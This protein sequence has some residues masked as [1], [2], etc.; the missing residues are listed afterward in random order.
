MSVAAAPYCAETAPPAL[1]SYS[2]VIVIVFVF[3]G[4]VFLVTVVEV[5]RRFPVSRLAATFI[6]AR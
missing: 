5:V 3:V 4:I 2:S 1:N 6:V